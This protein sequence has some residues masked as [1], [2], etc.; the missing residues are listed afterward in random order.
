MRTPDTI[1]ITGTVGTDPDHRVSESGTE[2]ASFRLASDY[3]RFN[4]ASGQW[5]K[6]PANWYT[7][8][9]YRSLAAHVA[10]CVAKGERVTVMGRIKI[11][12]WQS[13]ERGGTS[14]D[15]VADAVGLDLTFAPARREP[16]PAARDES[17]RIAAGYPSVPV[18]EAPPEEEPQPDA[19]EYLTSVAPVF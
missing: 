16:G 5:E 19:A 9:A 13:G 8:T 4:K 15:I 2:F 17:S 7:V 10:A 1:A 11:T 12:R 6:Q 3:S 14:V 18:P